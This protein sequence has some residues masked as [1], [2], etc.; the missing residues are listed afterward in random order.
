MSTARKKT[1]KVLADHKKVGKKF[2][3]PF[4]AKL[5]QL[6]EV[7]WVNDLVPELLWLAL[8]SDRHGRERG[9]DLARRLALAAVDARRSKPTSWFALAS[10]YAKL[11][12]SEQEAVV[13]K[14]GKDGA[15][16]EIRT[17]LSPLLTF[18]PE[19]PLRFLFDNPPE[20]EDDSLEKFKDVLVTIFDRW[21]TP[22]TFEQ[23]TAVYIAFCSGMLKVSKD[24]ALANFSAIEE[25]PNTEESHHVASGAR[26]TVSMF[27][28]QF[29]TDDSAVWVSYFWRRGLELDDCMF[30]TVTG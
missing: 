20:S 28:E 22:S 1:P 30:E 7:R 6:G 15:V 13:A 8:L 24:L 3:P 9:V 27:Y 23:A 25:F 18:Y 17:A 29:K 21:D 2:I 5:G 4:V 12:V 26:A 11:S 19:C 16:Q 14:L 10:A